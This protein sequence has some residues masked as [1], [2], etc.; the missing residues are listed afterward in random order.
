[1]TQSRA[2]IA[3]FGMNLAG[4][5]GVVNITVIY[6]ALP[7][8]ERALHAGIADQEWIVS[9]YPLMEGGFT[10]AAGTFG[11]LYG[12]KRI[13]T[14]TT[15]LF[16]L[17][18]IGC[19]LAPNAPALI[20]MRALQGLGGAALL[21]LPVAILVQ[22]LPKGADN[23]NVIK[24]FST[25]A[26]SGGIA[27][28]VIGG[29][30]VHFWGWPAVFY[31]SVVMGL[32]VLAT[33]HYA[34]E[35]E[36]DPSMRFDGLGQL[37]SIFSLL[38]I[39]FALIE[40]NASGWNSPIIVSAF[41]GSVLGTALFIAVERRVPKPMV[42]LRYFMSRGFVVG[43][44]MVGIINFC[45]YGIMLLCTN[46]LQNAQH[47]SAF[48]AGF[49]LMPA[50][51][52]FFAVNQSSSFF[53]RILGE[54][55]LIAVSWFFMLAGIAWLALLNVSDAS[56][57]V[58]GGLFV[59]GIGF[60]LLWTPACSFTMAACD[61]ANQGFASGAIAL[62]RSFF[63]VLGIAILGSLLAAG[64]ATGIRNDLAAMKVS[65]AITHHVTKAVHHGGA[66]AVAEYP[67]AGISGRT[68]MPI[69]EQSFGRGWRDAMLFTAGLSLLFGIVIYALIP[70]RKTAASA[71]ST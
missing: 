1:M 54:R 3:A 37:F 48:A 28:P 51:L 31:L 50:N 57:Q 56:W 47:I 24:T 64:M 61:A 43:L 34:T 65:P 39:S 52:A 32:I 17:A 70:T 45:F 11:D 59:L 19:A 66:F 23:E 4:F 27:G 7:Y 36:R 12:R 6:L 38:A 69:V 40:G 49:Y 5:T 25:V 14:I 9:I 67:P 20:V 26:G 55:M 42:H 60:G 71:A 13:L 62:S 53:E 29:I 8:I 2:R 16:V 46:F 21:S 33:L 18:T 68:L 41:A 58:S 44:L 35:S 10:L 22:M 30:A 15:W 63:G